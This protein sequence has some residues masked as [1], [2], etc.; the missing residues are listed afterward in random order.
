MKKS[1]TGL[2]FTTLAWLADAP[3]FIDKQLVGAFYDAVV[4]P[5]YE[6]GTIS[7]STE[8]MKSLKASIEAE[9]KIEVKPWE[10]IKMLLP[11]LDAKAEVKAGGKVE[12]E[13]EKKDEKTIELRRISTPQRQLVQLALHY[14]AHFSKR[15]AVVSEDFADPFWVNEAFISDV[16][17]ALVFF[18]FPPGTRFI[19]M[20][21]EL[22]KGNVVTVFNRLANT[23]GGPHDKPPSYP[24][25]IPPIPPNELKE[26]RKAYWGWFRK[27]FSPNLVMN[28]LEE[29]ITRNDGRIRW[30][31]FRVPLGDTNSPIYDER[32]LHLHICGR[33]E[34]DTGVFAY[35]LVG[36]GYK[37]GLRVV[38]TLKSEPDVNVLAIFE[39]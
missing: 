35:N 14:E 33:E 32:P 15:I 34:H 36:R 31:A 8:T 13:L 20:A 27:H 11:F 6:E 2:D 16:P 19:P 21:A 37:H 22:N 25:T 38:G 10:W 29:E 5:E 7:L 18:D 4:K 39:K 26:K 28:I 17:R 1:H 3:L 9:A 24:D 30:I 23:L 12:G